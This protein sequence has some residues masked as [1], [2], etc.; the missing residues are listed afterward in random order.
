MGSD[1]PELSNVNMLHTKIWKIIILLFLFNLIS[2]TVF[3]EE[4]SKKTSEKVP[5]KP[6][7]Q[8]IKKLPERLAEQLAETI[9]TGWGKFRILAPFSTQGEAFTEDGEFVLDVSV[10]SQ[11]SLLGEIVNLEA[12][13]TGKLKEELLN[14]PNTSG[15]TFHYLSPYGLGVGYTTIK[16]DLK[17]TIVA[18]EEI[19]TTL[20]I[21]ID[22][23][24]IITFTIPNRAILLT[25]KHIVA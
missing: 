15:I 2:L 5:E 7:K 23:P 18:T 22:S 9:G 19:L 12:R 6:T 14:G 21:G 17:S 16:T 10:D 1:L 20:A 25:F 8:P 11:V 24:P 3:S 13:V 4:S